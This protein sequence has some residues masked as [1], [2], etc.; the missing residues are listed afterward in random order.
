MSLPAYAA[1]R[2][3][4]LIPIMLAALLLTFLLTRVVP[5]DPTDL[6]AG[7][8]ATPAQR[9]A[10]RHAAHL[11]A[12]VYS[13]FYY[14]LRG[15][16]HGDLGTS[17]LTGHHVI[18]DLRDR[19]PATFE[20]V[21]Y[22][23]LV[24]VFVGAPLGILSA[25]RRGSWI[26]HL[27]RVISTIGTA[28]PV[29]WVGLG[30]LFIFYF[31]LDWLPGP[32]GRTGA[33]TSVSSSSITGMVT[34]DAVLHGDPGLLWQAIRALILPVASIALVTMPPIT[35]MARATMIE[36]LDSDYVRAARAQGLPERVVIFRHALKNT[37]VPL[38]T[39]TTAV[40]G[41]ALGG[42]VLV[43]VVFSWPGLGL[44]AYNAIINTDFPA[45]QGVVLLTAALYVLLYLALDI[46]TAVIDPRVRR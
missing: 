37:L 24:A 41:Y 20:L 23:M 1:R 45:V 33:I 13:Q 38:L 16:L 34:V 31:Q 40:Y 27:T 10:L 42:L 3:L 44:Y 5:G 25:L 21:T 8:Y 2:L 9:A 14:Y 18:K 12:P 30:A 7:P 6:V 11:D 43:E 26:D 17:F 46:A 28:V 15:V 19:F 22:A 29:F 35:R 39:I 4:L 32:V 36:V